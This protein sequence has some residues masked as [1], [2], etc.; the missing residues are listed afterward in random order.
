MAHDH[1]EPYVEHP[2]NRAEDGF[3]L[4]LPKPV[5][6][7]T[8]AELEAVAKRHNT[9][10]PRKM[11][12]FLDALA[13]SGSVAAA[14]RS[15]GM[16]RQSAYRVR[17]RLSGQPFD[18][19]WEAALE[20]GLQQLAH[21]A[22]DRALNGVEEPVFH[23][24]EQVGTRTRFDE[25]LTMFLL[26]NPARIGRHP[27]QR[28]MMLDAWDDLLSHIEH[29]PPLWEAIERQVEQMKQTPEGAAELAALDKEQQAR[30]RAF[31]KNRSHYAARDRDEDARAARRASPRPPR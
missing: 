1:E 27:L 14:A 28:E 24:G 23:A 17:A 7:L 11:A 5:S 6:E 4:G 29:G 16:S 18:I 31:F 21:A 26:A 10:T 2:D 15:V 20:F 8:P 3:P 19:A 22:L 13:S 25:R 30:S 9:W 12:R